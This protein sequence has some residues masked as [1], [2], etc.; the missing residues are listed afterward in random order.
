M[1]H[2][3]TDLSSSHPN[4]HPSLLPSLSPAR[5]VENIIVVPWMLGSLATLR[6]EESPI[7]PTIEKLRH[8]GLCSLQRPLATRLWIDD[9]RPQSHLRSRYTPTDR[10][11][12][13]KSIYTLYLTSKVCEVRL[14]GRSDN[15]SLR[16][17]SVK[18]ASPSAY[19]M[20]VS[21]FVVRV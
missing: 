7:S 9:I 21:M 19:H 4:F 18:P 12:R 16:F 15:A 20:Y 6:R 8:H 14:K 10:T 5:R 1:R 17:S 2:I 13:F 11:S 3:P